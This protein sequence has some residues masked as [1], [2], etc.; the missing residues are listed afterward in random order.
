M[1]ETRGAPA[2]PLACVRARFLSVP[3][4]PST[5]NTVLPISIPSRARERRCR[6]RG[7]Q[8]PGGVKPAPT[9]RKEERHAG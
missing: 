9:Y 8:R 6:R 1:R 5:T 4:S 2:M 3:S 7:W